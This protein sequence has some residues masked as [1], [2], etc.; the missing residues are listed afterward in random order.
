MEYCQESFETGDRQKWRL[1]PLGKRNLPLCLSHTKP[2]NAGGWRARAW[3]QASLEFS[4]APRP[5]LIS[6]V[7]P[8]PEYA[9]CSFACHTQSRITPA[10][11]GRAPG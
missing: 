11:G 3:A 9:I 4:A 10:D 8:R 6:P 2:D 1:M 5:A 7:S